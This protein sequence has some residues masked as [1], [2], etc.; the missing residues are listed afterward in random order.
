MPLFE[1][2]CIKVPPEFSK[3]IEGSISKNSPI[4]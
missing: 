4:F 1:P 2:V 3:K